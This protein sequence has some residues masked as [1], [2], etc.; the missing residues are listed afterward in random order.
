MTISRIQ[1]YGERCSG[2]N[3]IE[4]LIKLNYDI[5]ISY[6]Y[7]WKH[8]M[9]DYSNLKMN[10]NTLFLVV[11]RN[12]YDQLRSLYYQPHHAPHHYKLSMNEFLRK[13]WLSYDGPTAHWFSDDENER[14]AIAKP[15]YIVEEE[16]NVC[17][18]RNK[19]NKN[20]I[21]LEKHVENYVLI[22]YEDL[23]FDYTQIG[24]LAK[25]GLRKKL[26]TFVPVELYKGD[27]N[28]KY[29]TKDYPILS[30]EDIIFINKSLD[31]ELENL[32]GYQMSF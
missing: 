1:I 25:F 26:P 2:T 9:I 28:E 6:S 24:N 29:T 22:N 14:F 32:L 15:E 17:I 27:H 12:P 3:Y 11:V 20:F 8:W 18:L 19:K 4:S 30:I 16:E 13:K 31:W 23:L 5:E 7:G 21:D 10:D